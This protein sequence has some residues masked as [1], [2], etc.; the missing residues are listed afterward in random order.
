MLVNGVIEIFE[1]QPGLPEAPSQN[2]MAP[3]LLEEWGYTDDTTF[4]LKIHEGIKFHNLPPVNGREFTADDLAFSIE[5]AFS[6]GLDPGVK[7][8]VKEIQVADK[9]TVNVIMTQAI[10]ALEIKWLTKSWLVG[11]AKE[12]LDADGDFGRESMIGTGPYTV[13]YTHLRPNET[14]RNVVLRSVG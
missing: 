11:V 5:R 14:G 1:S 12:S 7:K 9:H 2:K 13:S 3:S 6:R 8:Y 4:R 10:P